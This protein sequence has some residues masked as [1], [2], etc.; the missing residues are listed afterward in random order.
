MSR[1]FASVG[2]C[3]DAWCASAPCS[4]ACSGSLE[5]SSS[6]PWKT[7]GE[8]GLHEAFGRRGL[9]KPKRDSVSSELD[10]RPCLRRGNWSLE[11]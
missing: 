8:R 7:S 2:A 10:A 9:T 11:G 4:T 6:P 3:S 1:G 5:F